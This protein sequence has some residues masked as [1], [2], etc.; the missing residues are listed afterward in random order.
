MNT[1][2][3]RVTKAAAE[4]AAAVQKARARQK[5]TQAQLASLSGLTPAAISQ[6]EAGLREPTFSTIV[7]IANALGTSPNDLM[8]LEDSQP[9]PALQLLYRDIKTL[10]PDDYDKV[11]AFARF[12]A[13]QDE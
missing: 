13:T 3:K 1:P 4:F 10:S 6:L 11:R 9:D 7:R 2:E 8:G 5:L 12:L